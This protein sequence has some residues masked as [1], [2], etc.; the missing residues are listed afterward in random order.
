MTKSEKIREIEDLYLSPCAPAVSEDL[1]EEQI[2]EKIRKYSKEM[3]IGLFCHYMD[4]LKPGFEHRF[5]EM[6]ILFHRAYIEGATLECTFSESDFIPPFLKSNTHDFLY[7]FREITSCLKD[8]GVEF[9]E[10]LDFEILRKYK[11]WETL[12]RKQYYDY[13]KR[14]FRTPDSLQECA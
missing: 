12:E 7:L 1:S 8:E 10:V 4:L 2:K 9:E 13:E 3:E 11:E 5:F 14:L 6:I